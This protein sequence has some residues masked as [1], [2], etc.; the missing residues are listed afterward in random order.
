MTYRAIAILLAAGALLSGCASDNPTESEIFQGEGDFTIQSG[1]ITLLATLDLPSSE[2]PHPAILIVPG[3][4]LPESIVFGRAF[5][6]SISN[7]FVIH[8]F[9]VLRYDKRGY[10]GSGGDYISP[11]ANGG[12]DML[13]WI[14][15]LA[16]DASACT[17][18]L[19]RH[20][21]IDP[22]QIGVMGFSEGG[23]TGTVAT[24]RSENVSFF[25]SAVGSA[26]SVGNYQAAD[27]I[28]AIR[29]PTL[30]LF[31]SV[32]VNNPPGESIPLLEQLVLEGEDVTYQ[33]YPN[34]NHDFVNEST[35]GPAFPIN[36]IFSWIQSR[37]GITP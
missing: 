36:D 30:W 6:R 9:A 28:R 17:D 2:G 20:Q 29:V 31:G 24:G 27:L 22:N 7:P 37:V 5:Y 10:G 8:G 12:R 14:G 23:R 34:V 26:R 21:D 25:I 18:F 19:S 3:G 4:G 11:W 35:G 1:D 15:I 13:D 16:D 32:D 33:V